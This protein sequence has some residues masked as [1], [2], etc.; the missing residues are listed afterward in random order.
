[1]TKARPANAQKKIWRFSAW[2]CSGMVGFVGLIASCLGIFAFT[3]GFGSIREIFYSGTSTANK[4]PSLE[5]TSSIM[6]PDK[7]LYLINGGKKTLLLEGD[8][9]EAAL[10][11]NAARVAVIG[12][13][14]LSL[15]TIHILDVD[16]SNHKA[17]RFPCVGVANAQTLAWVNESTVRVFLECR[18]PDGEM[19]A[20]LEQF[21]ISVS[22]SYD[23]TLDKFN[24]LLNVQLFR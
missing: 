10:S 20:S 8:L 5:I 13:G 2:A 17:F 21:P 16:G 4:R 3:T 7:S 24:S 6:K 19:T 15:R 11:G 12:Y 9:I 1:M 18:S 23:L 22:G 14:S